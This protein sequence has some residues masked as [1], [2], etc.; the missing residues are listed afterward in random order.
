MNSFTSTIFC[1]IALH[2]IDATYAQQ[3]LHKADET[4]KVEVFHWAKSE[5][6]LNDWEIS[7][8][9]PS[10]FWATL[11]K[12]DPEMSVGTL[13]EFFFAWRLHKAGNESRLFWCGWPKEAKKSYSF[14]LS[15]YFL[16]KDGCILGRVSESQGDAVERELL[17]R[18][19]YSSDKN[20]ISWNDQKLSVFSRLIRDTPKNTVGIM[21][22]SQ[23]IIA[24]RKTVDSMILHFNGQ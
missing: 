22:K 6:E 18:A 10:H 17:L 1:C 3:S 9:G 24:S 20:T 21:I 7:F 14:T 5:E 4:S 23:G 13:G 12:V 16:D 2:M 19:A 15:I 8:T 11:H